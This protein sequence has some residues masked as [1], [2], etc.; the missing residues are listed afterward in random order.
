MNQ[1]MNVQN[2]DGNDNAADQNEVNDNAE[3]E[4]L[5]EKEKTELKKA[6]KR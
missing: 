3:Q 5:A 1:M 6:Y 2:W 4:I